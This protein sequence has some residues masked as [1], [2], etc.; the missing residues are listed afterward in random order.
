M[1]NPLFFYIFYFALNKYNGQ[2]DSPD[3]YSVG[4][5]DFVGISKDEKNR[6]IKSFD[7][8]NAYVFYVSYDENII[9]KFY[10]KNQLLDDLLNIDEFKNENEHEIDLNKMQLDNLSKISIKSDSFGPDE[11]QNVINEFKHNKAYLNIG[12]GHN[13]EINCINF[14]LKGIKQL[15]YLPRVVFYP[16]TKEIDMEEIDSAFIINK[17]IENSDDYFK[18]FKSID[19]NSNNSLIRKK[20]ELN[21]NDLVFV[22]VSFVHPSLKKLEEFLNKIIKFTK[23][24]KTSKILNLQNHTIRP[25]LIF[26]DNYVLKTVEYNRLKAKLKDCFNSHKSEKDIKIDDIINNI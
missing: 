9:S 3:I 26:D 24:Y 14:L 2:E 12:G 4:F 13:Y 16:I 8:E 22:E 11:D 15:Q 20:I 17:L 1:I 7:S 6:N 5:W 10:S 21:E 19:F 23:L 18:N 25:I